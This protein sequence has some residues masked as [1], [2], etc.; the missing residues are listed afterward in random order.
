M[1]ARRAGERG[2]RDERFGALFDADGA[3]R[4]AVERDL[5]SADRRSGASHVGAAI[6]CRAERARRGEH[7][8]GDERGEAASQPARGARASHGVFAVTESGADC[9]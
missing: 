6:V 2:E 4:R 3:Q 8:A 7:A 1:P 9:V 5:Q